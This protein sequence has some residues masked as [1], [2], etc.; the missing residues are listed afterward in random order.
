VQNAEDLATRDP[1]LRARE[2]F[3][4][5]SEVDPWGAYGLDRFP[6]RFEGKRPLQYEGV[7][8]LGADTFDVFSGI[9]GLSDE[10]IAELMAGGVLS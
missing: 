9:L 3:G 6:A 1:N 10:Q 7:H 4:T 5:A 2:F 8:E